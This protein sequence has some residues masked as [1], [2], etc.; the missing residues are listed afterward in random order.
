MT[1][2][3]LLEVGNPS[4]LLLDSRAKNQSGSVIVASLEGT[5]PMLLEIQA[6]VSPTSFGIARRM[7]TGIDYNRLT[8][9]MAVLEK[10]VGMQLYNLDAYVNVVGGIRIDEPACDL[11]IIA[12]VAGSY[13]N[14]PIDSKV[15][16]MG[17][18]GLTGEIRPVNQVD[19][20]I[21]EAARLGFEKCLVPFGNKS[22]S[23]AGF[24]GI[25]VSYVATVEEALGH[26]F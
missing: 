15:V 26:L 19:K 11:G 9:L 7:A 21:S 25:E 20:R 16:V 10:K 24:D 4:A 22:N 8:M 2:Q 23:M 17:E 14:K 12:S 13:K 3:G 6:L 1:Q 18:V 5:R